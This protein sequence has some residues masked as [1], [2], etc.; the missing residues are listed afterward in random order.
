MVTIFTAVYNRCALMEKLYESLEQQTDK[1]F[2]W[3]IVDDGSTDNLHKKVIDD[4][5]Q[6]KRGYEIKYAYIRNGGKHRA[7]NLGVQMSRAEAFMIV[8]SDDY[9]TKDAVSFINKEFLSI[10]DDERF[11]GLSG[12]KA[13]YSNG[14][15]MGGVPGYKGYVDATNLERAKYNL[16]GDKAEVYKTDILRK[17]PFPEFDGE[18][19]CGEGIVFNHI[20]YDGYKIRWFTKVIYMAEYMEDGLTRNMLSILRDNPKGWAVNIKSQCEWEKWDEGKKYDIYFDFF[21]VESTRLNQADICCLLDIDQ[22]YYQR[23]VRE[24]EKIKKYIWK[25]IHDKNIKSLALYGMGVYGRRML[26]YLEEMG[27]EIRYAIDRNYKNIKTDYVLYG[28]ED[29]LPAVDSI[30][31]TLKEKDSWLEKMLRNKFP[32]TFIWNFVDF[33]ENGL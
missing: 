9:L 18:T 3:I 11:A 25:V 6:K 7:I 26:R 29:N 20:G 2:E 1:D 33:A 21:E 19:F 17:Y 27:I 13:F 15:V 24:K 22:A 10:A 23:M 12:L 14:E 28:L 32:N 16:L 31:I 4:W 5:I 8:D 30:C